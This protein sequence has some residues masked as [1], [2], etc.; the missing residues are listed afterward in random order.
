MLSNHFKNQNQYSLVYFENTLSNNFKG[1]NIKAAQKKSS[2]KFKF[3]N[4]A[5]IKHQNRNHFIITKFL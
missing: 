2:K 3:K 1:T 4:Y 5:L